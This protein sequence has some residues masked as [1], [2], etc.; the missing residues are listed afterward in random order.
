LATTNELLPSSSNRN[1][2]LSPHD[3][4]IAF[5]LGS[6]VLAEGGDMA[7]LFT[8]SK[9]VAS[10]P[11]KGSGAIETITALRRAEDEAFSA[12][13]GLVRHDLGL[14][15]TSVGG[16]HYRSR[17]V[18]ADDMARLREPLAALLDRL[19]A[20]GG[21]AT[22]YCPAGIGRHANHRA[23][24]NV[25]I[26]LLPGLEARGVQVRFYEDLHYAR[27]LAARLTGVA[28][29]KAELPG[30]RLVRRVHRVPD[31][32]AKLRL[33]N[34][35]QSQHSE[36]VRSLRRFSPAALWPLGAYEAWWEILPA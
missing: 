32:E 18:I 3:D 29:L 17:A 33:I 24:R 19:V 31:R 16:H 14:N 25:V 6:K 36:P 27:V 12:V 15:D 8:R 20:A 21:A 23:T 35:Y 10:G 30:R 11:L 5:S 9:N 4:D 1:I 13:A 22:L 7:V 34:L 28:E 26:E 2:L